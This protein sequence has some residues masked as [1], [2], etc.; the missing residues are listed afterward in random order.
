[1]IGEVSSVTSQVATTNSSTSK[2]NMDK[3]AFLKIF[4]AQL[5]Y[6]DPLNPA[7]GTEFIAELAQF[8]MLEQLAN[9]ADALNQLLQFEQKAQAASLIGKTVKIAGNGNSL[10]EG[11]VSAVRWSGGRVTLVVNDQEYDPAAVIEVK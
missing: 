1:M 4:L 7:N 10:V 3:D 6:Q 9:L 5:Q 8:G 11:L 2:L